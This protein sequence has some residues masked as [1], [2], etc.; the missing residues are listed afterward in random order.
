MY[1]LATFVWWSQPEIFQTV[2]VDFSLTESSAGFFVSAEFIALS[3][4]AFTTARFLNRLSLRTTC[5]VAGTIAVLCHFASA[6]I[7][8]YI[9]LLSLRLCAGIAEGIVLAIA[10]A[11][12]ASTPDPERSYGLLN[13]WNVVSSILLLVLITVVPL[14][15]PV[16]KNYTLV[17]VLIALA[18]ISMLPFANHIPN[19]IE[20][21]ENRHI[22]EN[23]KI[24]GALLLAGMLIWGTP[25]SSVW[26][27]LV[28]LAERTTLDSEVI[29][30]VVAMAAVGGLVGGIIA[31]KLGG[32][33]G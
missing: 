4:A 13:S 5:F 21:M 20:T 9:L 27:L 11:V 17:F 30:L 2:M 18:C 14:V 7:H 10:N 29:G 3:C 23:I 19:H 6:S 8:D 26:A 28:N 25:A 1:N 33:I 32:R 15:L 12:I 24:S 22:P 16:H 31:T